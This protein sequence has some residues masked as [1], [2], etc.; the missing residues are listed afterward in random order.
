MIHIRNSLELKLRLARLDDI[1]TYFEWV[2]EKFV[3]ENSINSQKI[4]FVE[5]KKWFDIQ[6]NSK[7]TYLYVLEKYRKPIGQIRFNIIQNYAYIDYSVDVNNRGQGIGSELITLGVNAFKKSNNIL[8]RAIVKNSNKSSLK[9]FTKLNFKILEK[10]SETIT[11]EI[12]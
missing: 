10:S 1:N 9:I 11:Y 4:S 5:H 2:N 12:K 7:D 3:R 8:I 6:I